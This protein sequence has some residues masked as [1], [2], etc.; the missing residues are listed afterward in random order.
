M[1]EQYVNFFIRDIIQ[2]TADAATFVVCPA[3]DHPIYY[4]P[5]QFITLVF[6]KGGR[7]VR[8]SYSLTS[9]PGIDDIICF[10]VKRVHNGE[11]SRLLLDNY[12][13]GDQLYALRPA[14]RFIFDENDNVPRD[15]FFLAA[16]SGITP[17]YSMIRYI[18]KQR[19]S[20]R[21][22]LVYQ[23]HT[24]A[25]TIFRKQ[26]EKLAVLYPS[27]FFWIDYVS[28]AVG[29]LS[30]KL[31]NDQ[32]ETLVQESLR[33]ER[34][35]ALFYICG[36]LSFMR[37]CEYTLLLMGFGREQLRKEYFVIDTPPPPPLVK[38]PV[39]RKVVAHVNGKQYTFTTQY[40]STILQSAIEQHIALPYSCKGARCAACIARRVSGEVAM[41]RNDVLTDKE[42]E[43]GLILT[44]VGYAVTDVEIRYD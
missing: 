36:P 12:K 14:G 20:V 13:A 6:T 28:N 31:T 18:L 16:G 5:G 43:Q 39:K 24:E 23:N 33:H 44:C 11:I 32:L 9:T 27:S 8:R 10:T 19:P 17:V 1:K 15:V 42:T 26:L 3:D 25:S 35:Q 34:S 41:S 4:K 40:P 21:V 29:N 37:M 38:K 22:V 7:E 2:E 30:R